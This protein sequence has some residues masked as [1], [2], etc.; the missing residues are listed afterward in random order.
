MVRKWIYTPPYFAAVG[1]FTCFWSIDRVALWTSNSPPAGLLT[2]D[3][4][5]DRGRERGGGNWPTFNP[6]GDTHAVWMQQ[7]VHRYSQCIAHP[8]YIHVYCRIGLQDR[9]S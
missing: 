5:T 1:F 2:T 8:E 3:T 4:D 6:E 7:A 9:G